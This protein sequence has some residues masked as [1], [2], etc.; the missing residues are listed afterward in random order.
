MTAKY[1]NDSLVIILHDGQK[2]VKGLT[3]FFLTYL[4]FEQIEEHLAAFEQE[5]KTAMIAVIDGNVAGVVT[6]ADT[7]KVGSKEAIRQLQSLGLSVWI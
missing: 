5:G 1:F 4:A 3:S 2:F 7:V 6:V